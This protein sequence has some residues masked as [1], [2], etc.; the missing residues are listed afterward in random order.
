MSEPLATLRSTSVRSVRLEMSV[1]SIHS[2]SSILRYSTASPDGTELSSSA[3]PS[4][5]ILS[6]REEPRQPCCDAAL[7]DSIVALA[8][9]AQL[10]VLARWG[11]GL[12]APS[13]CGWDAVLPVLPANMAG[14][15]LMGLLSDGKVPA[16]ELERKLDPT[17]DAA[18]ADVLRVGGLPL[19]MCPSL[20]GVSGCAA[21]LLGMRTGFCGSLTSFSTWSNF[22]VVDEAA[23]GRGG[24]VVLGYL[25]GLLLCLASL[26]AGQQLALFLSMSD[27]A[28]F[29]FPARLA[30]WCS[31]NVALVRLLCGI[32]LVTE[33]TFF[34]FHIFTETS[35][36][37]PSP[38]PVFALLFAPFGAWSRWRLGLYNGRFPTFPIGTFAANMI[39]C[40]LDALISGVGAT[41]SIS[42]KPWPDMVLDQFAFGFCGCLSTVSTFIAE[43]ADKLQPVSIPGK[44][45]HFFSSGVFYAIAS[46]CGGF[47]IG[48]VCYFPWRD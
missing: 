12:L 30:S 5:T 7:I 21:L 35:E 46:L 45:N 32:L 8:L 24:A 2:E 44:G 41:H 15:A 33:L 18:R 31:A 37:N 6:E 47:A 42:L 19:A 28:Y 9:C 14:C 26:R 48:C 20:G 36:S 40:A 23:H 10:G 13:R 16:A 34:L 17:D 27:R 1:G 39:A 3:P 29:S 4:L 22:L 11:F 25:F 38:A 43:V